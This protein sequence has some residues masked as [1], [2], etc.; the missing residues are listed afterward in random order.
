MTDGV[1][2]VTCSLWPE[3]EPGHEA[4]DAALAE[5][6]I[7]FSWVA[8]DDP[9]VDWASALVAVRST[10][11]YDARVEEFWAWAGRVPRMLNSAAIFR[12]NTDKAYLVELAGA[13]LDVVPTA[14]V[15]LGADLPAAIERFAPA[16]VKPRFGAGG[17]GVVVLEDADGP[18]PGTGP[19]VVQP[20]VESVRTEGEYS[21][22]VLGG[23]PRS[24]VRKLPA[25]EEIRV[26][27]QYGGTT[28]AVVPTQEATSLARRTV[29][30]AEQILG[31][32]L[33]YARVDLLRL[34]DGRLAVS[35][36]EV[37]EPGLY[38]DVLPENGAAFADVVA[39]A[40]RR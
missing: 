17:R 2:L 33:D 11:D 26:H 35:E 10:W 12:W 13:G 40:L 14:A 9:D 6:G 8:W 1:L 27:E 21:V 5:R 18:V 31:V 19:W 25:G 29:E 15:D 20:L 34:A 28:V 37:T 39:A 36:L 23:Q 7:S 16:V 3:G 24:A 30:V 32:R 38:L 4:L 22:Y